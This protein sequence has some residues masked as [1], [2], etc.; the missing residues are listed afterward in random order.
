MQPATPASKQRPY[1]A[2]DI[3]GTIIRWQLFHALIDELAKQ[4]VIDKQAYEESYAARIAWKQRANEEAYR[5][6]EKS[7]IA[8]YFTSI[9]HIT[10]VEFQKAADAA[11]LKHKDQVYRYTRDLVREL[12]A[13]GYLLFAISRSNEE[14][15]RPLAK[16]YGFDDYVGVQLVIE[17]GHYTGKERNDVSVSKQILLEQLISKHHAEQRGSM[18][19]GDSES[20]IDML[21]IAERPIAFNP[22]KKLFE[23]AKDH[24]WKVVLERKNMIYELE[25]RNSVYT[26]L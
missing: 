16:Y 1:A 24:N 7:L 6:Y 9:V 15:V 20:D 21:G 18:A 26:L 17:Q 4:N 3:D 5:T 11:V 2:F 10:P 8:T 25:P 22:T 12:K 13:Q 19:V 23:H 14:L